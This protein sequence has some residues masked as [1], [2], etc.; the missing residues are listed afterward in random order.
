MDSE[1]FIIRPLNPTP[2]VYQKQ[3]KE[4]K[5]NQYIFDDELHSYL[6]FERFDIKH[7]GCY[8]PVDADD[9]KKGDFW[10]C[11]YD[12][13]K[14]SQEKYDKM[15]SIYPLDIWYEWVDEHRTYRN[16]IICKIQYFFK[17][18]LYK[19]KKRFT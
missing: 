5:L 17:T 16:S 13:S 7:D 19:L 6:V 18:I 14:I 1:Y 2:T 11:T 9:F 3:K 12:K 8:S 15:K 10:F 4:E